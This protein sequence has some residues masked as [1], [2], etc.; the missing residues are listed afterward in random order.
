MTNMRDQRDGNEGFAEAAVLVRGFQLS[1]MMQVAAGLELADRI[2][3]G[4]KPVTI[5]ASECAAD[6]N[7]LWRMCRQDFVA[8]GSGLPPHGVL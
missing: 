4:P 6:A 2:A 5:L 8:F 7:M 3:D 1:T